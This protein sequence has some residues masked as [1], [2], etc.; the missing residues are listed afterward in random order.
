[1]DVN[2]YDNYWEIWEDADVYVSPRKYAGQSLPLN[3]AMSLGMA[4]MMTDMEPQNQFLPSSFLSDA[5]RL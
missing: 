2:D 4:V 3:E 5:D 1:M